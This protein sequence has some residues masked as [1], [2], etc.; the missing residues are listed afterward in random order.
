MRTIVY[1]NGNFVYS[2]QRFWTPNVAVGSQNE[3]DFWYYLFVSLMKRRTSNL[4]KK[5]LINIFDIGLN[6]VHT[7][8][9]KENITKRLLANV[10]A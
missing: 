10:K 8:N 9:M 1:M 6:P 2:K 3:Q 5:L 4:N 7:K